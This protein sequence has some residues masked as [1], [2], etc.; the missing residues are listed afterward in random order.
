[1]RADLI[2]RDREGRPVLVVEVKTRPARQ[3][4]LQ[5]LRASID[6]ISAASAAGGIVYGMLVDPESIVVLTRNGHLPDLCLGPYRTTEVL[7]H[8]DPDFQGP[9]GQ[10]VS[11]KVF[12][13]YLRG[14]VEGWFQDLVLHWTE[15]EPPLRN[16]LAEVGLLQRLE[17]GM[18][19]EEGSVRDDS[20]R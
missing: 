19:V 15:G 10:L 8:Y 18:V 4:D 7:S 3:T 17:D 2:A 12:G 5:Q 11:A 14:L 16:E 6:T 20:L 9:E 1:M 13:I